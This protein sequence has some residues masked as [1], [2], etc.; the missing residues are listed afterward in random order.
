MVDMTDIINSYQDR[1]KAKY[2]GRITRQQTRAMSAVLD[3]RT[4]R[5]GLMKLDCNACDFHTSNYQAGG[6]RAAWSTV[7]VPWLDVILTVTG[8]ALPS[9]TV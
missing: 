4:A 3:C 2:A 7:L 5:Y 9:T 8:V 1:F 6:K